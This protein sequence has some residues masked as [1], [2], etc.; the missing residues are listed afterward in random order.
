[1]EELQLCGKP[2]I[3]WQLLAIWL[4]NDRI[5]REGSFRNVATGQEGGIST[6]KL[7]ALD[8]DY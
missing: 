7:C 5:R 8:L 1:V 2:V 4:R 3:G 6:A